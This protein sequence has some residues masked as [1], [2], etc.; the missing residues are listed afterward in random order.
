M[1]GKIKQEI[2]TII[3]NQ[4]ESQLME[5]LEICKNNKKES[6]ERGGNAIVK[7]NNRRKGERGR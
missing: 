2:S 3:L 4:T 7:R 1:I 5:W 6:I